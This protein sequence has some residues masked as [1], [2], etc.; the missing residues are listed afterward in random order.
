MQCLV[1]TDIH[2]I[3]PALR[4]LLAPLGVIQY[5]SPWDNQPP[6][7]ADETQNAAAFHAAN[8][9]HAYAARINTALRQRPTLLI[10]FSVGAASAWH[11][12]ASAHCATHHLAILYY[13]SRIRDALHLVPRCPVHLRFAERE[14]A[15]RPQDLLPALN[16]TANTRATLLPGTQHGFMNPQHPAYNPT[17]AKREIRWLQHCRQQQKF[18]DAPEHAP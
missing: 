2:G 15:F 1:A 18:V 17:L 3:T 14:S 9:L 8:G 5:L 4:T 10:A 6:P 11:A 13:G 16:T 12:I 7:S